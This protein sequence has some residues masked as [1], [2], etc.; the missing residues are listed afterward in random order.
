MI[1]LTDGAAVFLFSLALP[2]IQ[3]PPEMLGCWSTLQE[4]TTARRLQSKTVDFLIKST[5]SQS[6]DSTK[7][8]W[9]LYLCSSSM[10]SLINVLTSSSARKPRLPGM[11]ESREDTL[12]TG[13]ELQAAASGD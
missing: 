13:A 4:L 5:V 11:P 2:L 1:L 6:H 9:S 8:H 7:E 10:L 3:I 12:A